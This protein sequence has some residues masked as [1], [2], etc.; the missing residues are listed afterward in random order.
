MMRSLKRL[1]LAMVAGSLVLTGCSF[2]G[3]Y[4]LPLPG[5]V[6]SDSDGYKVTAKFTD[7][8]S[9]VPR[10]LVMAN[11]VP[12]GQ[13]DSV[14]RDGW[15]AKVVMTIKKSIVLPA[16]AMAT[17]QQTSLLG[18]KY[19]SLSAPP[20]SSVAKNGRL[21]NGA[22]IG[23]NRTTRDAEVE[24][25]LGALSALLSGG[26]VGQ[27][28]NI[29]V[30]LNKAMDGRQADVRGALQQLDTFMGGLDAQKSDIIAALGSVNRLTT[31][32]N[33]ERNTIGAALD[34]FGPALTVLNQQHAGLVKMLTSL[35]RL[36]KVGTNV[37]Q[38]SRANIVASLKHLAPTLKG[39]SDAGDSLVPGL[40][41]MA[42]FPFPAAAATLAKGDYSNALFDMKFDLNQLLQGILKGGNTQVLPNIATLCK[43]YAGAGSCAPL[44]SALCTAT[45]VSI[46]C[47]ANTAGGILSLLNGGKGAGAKGS[48][49]GS[50]GLLGGLLGGSSGTSNK[51]NN[52]LANL[53]GGLL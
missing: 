29:S 12:V 21:S 47:D 16:N 15:D 36:G 19:I 14:S 26:G 46:F 11:D 44:M 50:K 8:V 28:H 49:T 5:K 4:D 39:L 9:V 23:L 27:L 31:T 22:T 42:S 2:N 52:P 40:M 1:V 3:A 6:V 37:I 24:D 35:D 13:V 18:E 48:K 17:V 7:V 10:T 38:Q 30:E 45:Q 43:A 34:S 51:P 20:G 53:L 41:L 33:N 25:V 32:L